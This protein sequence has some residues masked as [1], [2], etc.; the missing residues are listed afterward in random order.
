MNITTPKHSQNQA[1]PIIKLQQWATPFI[2]RH[3]LVGVL[4]LD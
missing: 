3:K 4:G 2:P 1:T